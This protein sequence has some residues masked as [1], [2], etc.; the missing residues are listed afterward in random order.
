CRANPTWSAFCRITRQ[1]HTHSTPRLDETVVAAPT[2][3]W[4][5]QRL[6]HAFPAE[7]SEARRAARCLRVSIDREFEPLQW[8]PAAVYDDTVE[9]HNAVAIRLVFVCVIRG[10]TCD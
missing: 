3:L 8:E 5:R 9:I 10:P 4:L 1:V 6:D 2:S 7:R